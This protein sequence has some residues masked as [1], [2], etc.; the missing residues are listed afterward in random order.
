MTLRW[1]LDDPGS[2]P[3]TFKKISIFDEN[4]PKLWALLLAQEMGGRSPPQFRIQ[5]SGFKIQDSGF[6]IQNAMQDFRAS[7]RGQIFAK[8]QNHRNQNR[9]ILECSN[10][11]QMTLRWFLDTP[12]PILATFKKSRFSTKIRQNLGWPLY[13]IDPR[14]Q[15]EDTGGKINK[16]DIAFIPYFCWIR[17]PPDAQIR[18]RSKNRQFHGSFFIKIKI[19]ETQSTTF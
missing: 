7:I 18:R 19:F 14:Q 16:I 3:A 8:I 1:F 13:Q 4:S 5:D 15:K 12:G 10:N 17:A 2:I 6:R 11:F 9:H